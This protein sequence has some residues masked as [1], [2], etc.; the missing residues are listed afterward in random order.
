MPQTVEE[1]I[2]E[3]LRSI[4]VACGEFE[5]LLSYFRTHYNYD[6]RSVNVAQ[7]KLDELRMWACKAVYDAS[8]MGRL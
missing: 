8:P 3:D 4:E 2:A 7:T 5:T 1:R 6:G